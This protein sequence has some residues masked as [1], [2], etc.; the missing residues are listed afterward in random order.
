MTGK[1]AVRQQSGAAMSRNLARTLE[2]AE[3][4]AA[5]RG[6][7]ALTL[8][9]VLLSFTEDP[10]TLRSFK[11]CGVSLERLREEISDVLA[12]LPVVQGNGES[13]AQSEELAR[14]MADA[15]DATLE[16]NRAEINSFIVLAALVGNEQ[17]DAARLLERHGFTWEKA[18]QALQSPAAAAARKPAEPVAV[19][20]PEPLRMEA[21]PV[22]EKA[23]PPEEAATTTPWPEIDE[24]PAPVETIPGLDESLDDGHA[25]GKQPFPPPSVARPASREIGEPRYAAEPRSKASPPQSGKQPDA[26]TATPDDIMASV[27]QKLGTKPGAAKRVR[28]TLDLPLAPK[29]QSIN[30]KPA[31]QPD[32]PALSEARTPSPPSSPKPLLPPEPEQTPAPAVER[33]P[34]VQRQPRPPFNA[35]IRPTTLEALAAEAARAARGRAEALQPPWPA[36]PEHSPADVRGPA[37]SPRLVD[38]ASERSRPLDDAL[39]EAPLPSLPAAAPSRPPQRPPE[40]NLAAL[41]SVWQRSLS[42][43]RPVEARIDLPRSDLDALVARAGGS[44]EGPRLAVGAITLRLKAEDGAVSIEPRS[45]ETQW[46][47]SADGLVEDGVVRWS[48][49]LSPQEKGRDTLRLVASIRT[50]AADGSTR[51][52]GLDDGRLQIRVRGRGRSLLGWVG[53]SLAALLGGLEFYEGFTGSDP[54][55]ELISSARAMLF[56]G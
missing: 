39:L 34:P 10:D 28:P 26:N 54:L 1:L 3:R 43:G 53:W 56:G 45:P 21:A 17:S 24:A 7:A 42:L 18:I 8:E 50:L 9:H 16:A 19:A 47:E 25:A 37:Q 33:Q 13:P 29:W 6:H 4:H 20:E 51:D 40:V 49:A 36:P 44:S 30:A 23:A 48:W 55:L 14:L 11:A 5:E 22:A 46:V 31:V 2:R 32:E 41:M 52:T 35:G 12:G 15:T 38:L 27:R